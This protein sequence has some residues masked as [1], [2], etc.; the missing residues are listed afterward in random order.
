MYRKPIFT[1]IFPDVDTFKTEYTE[2]ALNG[3]IT[4]ENQGILYYLLYARYGNSSIAASD[5]LR[6]KYQLYS[7][8]FQYGPTWEK[9]LQIQKE[10]RALN[11][12][13]EGLETGSTK[14]YNLA[15]NP[16]ITPT[17]QTLSELPYVSQQNVS[18]T[19]RGKVEQYAMILDLLQSDVSERFLN[20]FAKLF[21]KFVQPDN[22]FIYCEGDDGPEQGCNF[23]V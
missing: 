20:K 5:E 16:D 7:I 2:S 23:E 9:E 13:D 17:D 3:A 11:V 15:Q 14:I 1:E 21:I 10:V 12:G 4:D 8:I 22:D 18:K 19:K 6:F